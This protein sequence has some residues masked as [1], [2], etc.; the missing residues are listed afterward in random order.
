MMYGVGIVLIYSLYVF[1]KDTWTQYIRHFSA[2]QTP[3]NPDETEIAKVNVNLRNQ[4][5]EHL[6]NNYKSGIRPSNN[7]SSIEIAVDPGLRNII[8]VVSYT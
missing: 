5:Y 2:A 4:L 8:R 3:L 1:G 7:G 6:F